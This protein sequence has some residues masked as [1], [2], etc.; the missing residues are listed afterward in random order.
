MFGMFKK[1]QLGISAKETA[2]DADALEALLSMQT[3]ISQRIR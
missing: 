2:S 1:K 3:C